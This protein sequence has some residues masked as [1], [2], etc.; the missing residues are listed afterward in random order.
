MIDSLKLRLSKLCEIG[1]S[2]RAATRR[3]KVLS[4]GMTS[5]PWFELTPVVAISLFGSSLFALS[6]RK[7]RGWDVCLLE[8]SEKNLAELFS[9][10]ESF[11]IVLHHTTV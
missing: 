4:S 6:R 2:S 10:L 9:I 7:L 11:D 1:R 5:S 8:R 3:D